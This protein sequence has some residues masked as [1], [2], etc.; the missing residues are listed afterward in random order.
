MAGRPVK[1]AGI[2]V[3]RHCRERFQQRFDRTATKATVE[4]IARVARPLWRNLKRRIDKYRRE[5]ELKPVEWK[6]GYEYYVSMYRRAMWV[7]KR[8]EYGVLILLTVWKFES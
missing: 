8:D 3:T 2:H 5:H 7:V 6:D 4:R 1:G